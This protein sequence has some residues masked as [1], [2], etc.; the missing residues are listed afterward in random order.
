MTIL[1]RA[2][3]SNA[4][5]VAKDLSAAMDGDRD[6]IH[7]VRVASRRLRAALP[8]ASEATR[9]D[10]RPLIRDVR[11]V[12]RAFSGLR[13]ADVV[14]GLVQKWPSSGSWSALALMRLETRCDQLRAREFRATRDALARVDA[15]EMA[16]HCRTVARSVRQDAEPAALAIA[17]A[18]EV[19]RRIRDV[20]EAVAETG[21]VYAVEPL[22]RIRIAAK[23]LRYTLEVGSRALAGAGPKARRELRLL[24]SRLGDL[25]DL[26]ILQEHVRAAA[27]EAA[28]EPALSADLSQMDGVIEVRC[29]QAHAGILR[30]RPRLEAA[31][32][33]VD[34]AASALIVPRAVGRPVRMPRMPATRRKKTAAG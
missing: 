4:S 32:H 11:R 21:I 18:R 9:T 8:I 34:R 13:E 31:L 14:L 12:T 17:L 2:I 10:I 7:D 1:S 15:D 30:T 24:Q 3:Q 29:R 27:A 19:R 5:R 20:E 25:H 16:A 26:Q 28:A 23:K 6:A 33:D 22:H